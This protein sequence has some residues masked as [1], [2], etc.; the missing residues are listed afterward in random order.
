MHRICLV[1][2]ASL[3]LVVQP[4]LATDPPKKSKKK[5]S[6]SQLIKQLGDEKTAAEAEAALVELGKKA[7]GPLA[8]AVSSRNEALR[9][10]AVSALG[11]I[12]EPAAP[13]APALMNQAVKGDQSCLD[14]VGKMGIKALAQ[15]ARG[16]KAKDAAIRVKTAQLIGSHGDKAK[17]G[18]KSL[19]VALGKDKE[20][21]VRAASATA[22]GKLGK[23]GL[24]AVGSLIKALR[25]KDPSVG[26]AARGA[27]GSLAD[28]AN[29]ST[30]KKIEKAL[31]AP[32]P[33]EKKKK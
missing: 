12:G 27:L 22:L 10:R 24:P 2:M 13:A 9:K 5:P 18:V 8:R 19:M 15:L 4:A 30:K 29:K 17:A 11:Q 31:A 23:T 16:L 21:K 7:V 14:A 20:A 28:V 3:A 26:E 25:D 32:K 1:A 6:V 33:K